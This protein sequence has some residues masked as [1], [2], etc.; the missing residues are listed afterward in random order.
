MTNI[1]GKHID[2]PLTNIFIPALYLLR[3]V[4]VPDEAKVHVNDITVTLGD[5]RTLQCSSEPGNPDNTQF[6]WYHDT[7]GYLGDVGKDGYLEWLFDELCMAGVFTC[8]PYNSL[9]DG[10]NGTITVAIT[11]TRV[12]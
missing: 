12:R 11:G 5:T 8:T 1:Y 3:V 6:R 10:G 2:A 9:G 7:L 4:V